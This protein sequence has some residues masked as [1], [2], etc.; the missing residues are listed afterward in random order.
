MCE[1]KVKELI[2]LLSKHLFKD[3]DELYNINLAQV[4]SISNLLIKSNIPYVLTF[5]EGTRA[6]AKTITLQITISP[7]TSISKV[8][9]LEEGTLPT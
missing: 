1:E 2:A 7:T 8:Y 4:F 9:Q 6:T 5:S 3:C